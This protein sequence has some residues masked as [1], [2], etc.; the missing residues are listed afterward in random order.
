VIDFKEIVRAK[1][2]EMSK[3][4]IHIPNNPLPGGRIGMSESEL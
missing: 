2:E 1:I 4:E 3:L